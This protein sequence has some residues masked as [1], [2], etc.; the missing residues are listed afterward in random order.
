MYQHQQRP[1]NTNGISR[2]LL[3]TREATAN[4]NPNNATAQNAF[5]QLLLKANLP[6]IVVERYESGLYASSD[7]ADAAYFRAL[8]MAKKVGATSA[9]AVTGA[10]GSDGGNSVL[11]YAAQA[12]AARV[13][14][15]NAATATTT[16]SDAATGNQRITVVVEESWGTV[17]W[18]WARTI[19]SLLLVAYVAIVVVTL[20]VGFFES[21]NDMYKRSGV[22]NRSN[23][24][25]P[26]SQTTRFTDVHGCDEAKEELQEAVEFLRDPT[27]F[28][29]LGGKL[30]KG[31]LLV[32]PPGTGKTLL[33]RA[34]AGEAG[35][36]FFYMSGSEFDEVW[37]GLGAKRVRDLF[38]AAKAKSPSIIFIDELDAVGSKRQEG[39][40]AYLK[41]TL[42]QLLTEMDGFE[43]NTGVIVIAATNHPEVLDKA[44]TRPGRF[45]RHVIVGLP[46]ARG[47]LAIL[48]HH[49]K[50]IKLG[51][52]IKLDAI[53][54]RTSGLSGADLENILNQAA[55]HASKAK[56]KF[57]G[58]EHMEWAADKVMMGA[59]RQL[60][61]TPREKLMTAYHE[62][63]H[64][65]VLFFADKPPINL[66]K[67]TIL[68]RGQS[69]GHTALIPEMDKHSYTLSDYM[70]MMRVSLGGKVAEELAF[71]TD[72]VTSG[73]SSVRTITPLHR[74][75]EC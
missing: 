32:G 55:V 48:K 13:K 71:G 10:Q 1:V 28:S 59:E 19:F 3:A 27:G 45:D 50:K 65:L 7:A 75:T 4:R 2:S 25:R 43:S 46:D 69:L 22:K 5:Y 72:N 63:G 53:A 41:Q 47:R 23:E 38:A 66:H 40:R 49:G 24:V 58:T 60:I 68:A 57:V 74:R 56:A 35:V 30:P 14:G 64:A 33:A 67:V 73:V 18:R 31:V 36:P 20:F 21:F 9:A 61:A 44:L 8:D 51:K 29:S 6:N 70:T 26:E 37:V 16:I 15:S 42:N 17:V 62:A 39:D 52:D 54:A 11:Q 34:V 12:V